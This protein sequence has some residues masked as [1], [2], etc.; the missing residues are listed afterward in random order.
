MLGTI[1]WL[2]LILI[3]MEKDIH[4]L[5]QGV[6]TFA[7]KPVVDVFLF[8]DIIISNPDEAGFTL[9]YEIVLN[10]PDIQS[11]KL[12]W[13]LFPNNN[14]N[15]KPSLNDIQYSPQGVCRHTITHTPNNN[16]KIDNMDYICDLQPDITYTIWGAIDTNGNG[17]MALLC[18][19]EKPEMFTIIHEEI[20]VE[21]NIFNFLHRRT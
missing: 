11:T 3:M 13:V 1:L 9:S 17:E 10:A 14:S 8:C 21:S 6:K 7:T 16:K 20:Y 4:R 5:G 19:N 2:K 18:N 12:Y 15:I